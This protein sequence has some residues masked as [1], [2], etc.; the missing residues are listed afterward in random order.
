MRKDSPLTIGIVTISFNQARFLPEAIESVQLKDPSRLRYVIVDPGSKDDSRAIIEKYK[1]KFS[2]RVL[3]PDR[4]PSDGLNKGFAHCDADI[5][6]YLNADDRLVPGALDYVLDFFERN[7]DV[8]IL[9]GA[10]RILDEEGNARPRCC[11]PWRF[12]PQDFL[13]GTYLIVQQATF[14]RRRIWE[15][16]QGFNEQNFTCWDTEHIMDMALAGAKV[17]RVFKV[18]GEFRVYATSI[19]GSQLLGGSQEM[20][21]KRLRD[22]DRIQKKVLATG[23]KPTPSPIQQMKKLVFKIHPVRRILEF[24]TR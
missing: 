14:F 21:Q 18:L 11:L 22:H 15:K 5:L 3:E 19:C 24:T 9:M 12:S 17:H 1:D 2:E 6:G 10:I 23:I 8:D 4:G 13:D 20:T 16:T 7:P